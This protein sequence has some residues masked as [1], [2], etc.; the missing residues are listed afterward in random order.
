[1]ATVL[2]CGANTGRLI[3][4]SE[5]YV[6]PLTMAIQY[7][8]GSQAVVGDIG[9][10]VGVQVSMEILAQFRNALSS[11]IYVTPFG[12][13]PGSIAVTFIANEEECGT[14]GSGANNANLGVL[15]HY[16]TNRLLPNVN[17][18]LSSGSG[19]LPA[20]VSIGGAAFRAFLTGVSLDGSAQDVP[21]IRGTLKFTAWPQA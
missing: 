6:A 12:D 15:D 13:R 8:S 18:G 2:G 3:A 4:R 19:R 5:N 14:S 20:T 21:L 17:N 11:A 10:A 1:M 16:I 9:V 7:E